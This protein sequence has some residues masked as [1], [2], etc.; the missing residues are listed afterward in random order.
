MYNDIGIIRIKWGIN[1]G[2]IKPVVIFMAVVMLTPMLM[3]CSPAK[4]KTNVVKEDDPW[5]E[6]TRFELEKNLK[7]YEELGRSVECTS[8]NLIFSIYS[9]SPDRWGTSQ[10]ILDTY[11]LD[12]KRIKHTEVTSPDGARVQDIYAVGSDPE[13]KTLSAV[14]FLNYS[15]RGSFSFADIDV[16]TGVISN[17]QEVISKKV[18]AATGTSGSLSNVSFIGDYAVVELIGDYNAGRSSQ[19]ELMLF[20]DREFLTDFDMSTLNLFYFLGGLSIDESTNTLHATGLETN[21]IIS[22]VFDINNGQLKD[23]INIQGAEGAADD[24]AEYT[25]TS[26]GDMCKLD[27]FGNIVKL[28]VNSMTPQTI[29]DTNWYTPFFPAS[30]G[31]LSDDRIGFSAGIVSCNE[32]RTIIIECESRSYGDNDHKFTEYI[33]VLKKADKNPHAGKQ[34]IELALPVNSGVSYYLASAIYEFNRSDSEYILRVWDKYKNGTTLGM[35]VPNA[36]ENET[37]LFEMIQDLKDDGA[38]DIAIG[39]QKDYAMRDDVFMDLTGFIDPDVAE[40]QYTNIF[41]AGKID[42]K[43]YFLPV[44][45]EIEGLVTNSDLLK[46]GAE[47]ITFEEFDKMIK[48]DLDGFSPYDH[49]Y[50]TVYNK[51]DFILSCIDTKSVIEG[52]KVDFGTE[53]FR[54][55]VEYANENIAYDDLNSTPQEYIYDIDH[56]ERTECYYERINDYLDYVHACYSSK[57]QYVIIGTPSVDASGPRFRAVETISVS[58]TTDVTEGCRRFI[59]YLFSGAAV[60]S[61][62]CDFMEIVTNRE[63]MEKNVTTLSKNN[64][65]AFE[66]YQAAKKSAAI[67]PNPAYERATGDKE[68]TDEMCDSF[69]YSMSTIS[70]YY[71]EDKQIVKFVFEEI[72]PYYVGD[73]SLDDAIRFLNDRTEKYLGEM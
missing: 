58:A 68:S 55:A 28:D 30:A 41:E 45:L 5:Y 43:L 4:K 38:P 26:D 69:L 36:D 59:N 24:L 71:Y 3:S 18:K 2:K 35:M 48:E 33:R 23:K 37:E 9:K 70:T 31:V 16:E 32:D 29:V 72:S 47:G 42:G 66:L 7:P 46:D 12:G 34:I 56:R 52:E 19:W 50:S 17:I 14:F 67:I 51:R 39:I 10:M 54:S 53:Q 22:M 63:I 11:D 64:N 49:Q 1:M 44:T 15:G 8:G 6:S 25:T 27:S 40:K 73:R 62:E 20:K 13:G 61:G 21:G 60:S 65:E 57:G